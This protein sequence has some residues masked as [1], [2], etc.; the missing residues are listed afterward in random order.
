M[1]SWVSR[2]CGC[3]VALHFVQPAAAQ[4][5]PA[6][7]PRVILETTQ[8]I[9]ELKLLPS[10]APKACENFLGLVGKGYYDGIIFHRVIKQFMIQGGDPTGSGRGGESV[11]GKPFA[12]ELSKAVKFDKPGILAMANAGPST[13]GSQFF[14]TTVPTPWLHMKHT[15]FG[16]VVAGYE[17]V[18]KIENTPVG[19]G[20]RPVQEQKIIRAYIK[21]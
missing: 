5:Q 9:I 21:K 1:R 7:E 18:Q 14:I 4:Q 15:I 19:P 3:L 16:E 13:N 20:D 8:G 2:L 17:I 12:D 11:W 10:V 6:G